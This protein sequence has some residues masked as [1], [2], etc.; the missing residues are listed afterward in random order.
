MATKLEPIHKEGPYFQFKG[1]RKHSR[2]KS[3]WHFIHHIISNGSR[4]ISQ[5]AGALVSLVGLTSCPLG[6]L[7]S[8]LIHKWGILRCVKT[9]RTQPSK[10]RGPRAGQRLPT[11]KEYS[12]IRDT[13]RG[14]LRS[15]VNLQQT[16]GLSFPIQAAEMSPSLPLTLCLG[17]QKPQWVGMMEGISAPG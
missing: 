5:C 12:P 11:R 14:F 1:R 16:L 3:P 9:C 13:P 6:R 17:D 8:A 4:R 7:P 2:I 15:F 10:P